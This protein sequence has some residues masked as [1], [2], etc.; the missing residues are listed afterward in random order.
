MSTAGIHPWNLAENMVKPIE[1]L[2]RSGL[3]GPWDAPDLDFDQKKA[4]INPAGCD[5]WGL[6]SFQLWPNFVILV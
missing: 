5:P 4:G 2:T 6:D 1:I 3:F